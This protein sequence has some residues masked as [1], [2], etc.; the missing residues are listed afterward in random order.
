MPVHGSLT[1]SLKRDTLWIKL[2]YFCRTGA[3]QEMAAPVV[4]EFLS[5]LKC[6]PNVHLPF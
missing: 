4:Q 6:S 3:V 2:H 1:F 5:D